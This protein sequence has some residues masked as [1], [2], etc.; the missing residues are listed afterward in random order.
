MVIGLVE[1]EEVGVV[2]LSAPGAL[3]VSC[4]KRVKDSLELLIDYDRNA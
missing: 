2:D 1:S 3:I 4:G